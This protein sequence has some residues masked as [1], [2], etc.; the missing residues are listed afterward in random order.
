MPARPKYTEDQMAEAITR[1]DGNLTV[2][3]KSLKCTRETVRRYVNRSLKLGGVLEDARET[4]IDFAEHKLHE[5]IQ[6][7]NLIATIFF[8]KTQARHRGY[9][10]RPEPGSEYDD[11]ETVVTMKLGD[12]VLKQT[13]PDETTH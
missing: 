11:T 3:A 12:K 13:P 10:E 2:A 1:A 6:N 5:H 8:L 7:D 9:I 4:L